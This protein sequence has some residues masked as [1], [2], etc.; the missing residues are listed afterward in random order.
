MRKQL[1]GML[2]AA[3]LLPAC[4]GG[5]TDTPE[6]VTPDGAT[7]ESSDDA[8]FESSDDADLSGVLGD[9]QL[10]ALAFVAV[11]FTGVLIGLSP[12]ALRDSSFD[13]SAFEEELENLR[14]YVPADIRSDGLAWMSLVG[15]AYSKARAGDDAGAKAIIESTEYNSLFTPIENYLNS[16]D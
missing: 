7:E 4:G 2:A 15:D 11:G 10:A 13:G 3:A 16:C 9:C 14:Q 8:G 1:V 6:S 12:E 5:T